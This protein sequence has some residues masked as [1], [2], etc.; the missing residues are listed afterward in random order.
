MPPQDVMHSRRGFLGLCGG[1]AAYAAMPALG[2]DEAS[3]YPGWRPGELDIH[4]IR[5]GVGEQTFFIMPDGTTM[6]LD[7]GD[8][9][10]PQYL[11]HVPRVPSPDRLGGEWVS[12]YVQRLVKERSVDYFLLSHWHSDH[13][14][15]P[16]RRCETAADGRKVCGITRFAED[17]SIRHYFDHQY[18]RSGVHALNPSEDSLAMMREWI[19]FME[20]KRGMKA[21]AFEVGAANQIAMLRDPKAYSGSFEIRNLFAN[22]VHWDGKGGTVDYAPEYAKLKPGLGGKIS[23]N[24]LSTGIRIRYGNFSA[25]FGGDIDFPDYEARIGKIVGPV[26]VCKMNHHG[27]PSSMGSA[28]CREVMAKAYVSCVWSPNQ[29]SAKNMVNMASRDLYGGERLLMPDFLPDVRR[30]EYRGREFMKD[31]LD[32]AGHHV[33]KVAPGGG[34]FEAFVLSSQDESMSVL[35]RRAFVSGN[36]AA[37]G[38]VP[39]KDAVLEQKGKMQ[40]TEKVERCRT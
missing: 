28:F 30:E 16:S 24:A 1:A 36:C 8:F 13:C 38:A 9:Y 18:P 31:V 7:C 32:I 29:I 21:H 4:F 12:R 11:K 23:E 27:H 40:S 2:V 17:F 33:F 10:R 22:A 6:L 35:W 25:Y 3:V 14:G 26:D 5:T 37:A 15:G 34:T 20:N 19:P 39:P